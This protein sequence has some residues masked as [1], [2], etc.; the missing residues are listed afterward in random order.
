M[1]KIKIAINGANGRMGKAISSLVTPSTQQISTRTSNGN[2]GDKVTIS[3][4]IVRDTSDEQLEHIC[5]NCDVIVDFS[6]P[7]GL[8]RLLPYIAKAENTKL[9]VGTTG[10]SKEHFDALDDIS[11]EASVIYAP[12]TSLGANLLEYLSVKASNL[13]KTYDVEI[14]EAHHRNKKDSPSGTAISL[15][16]AIAEAKDWEFAN[17]AI[18]DRHQ[19]GL[20]E[21]KDIS[22]ASIRGGGIFG[23]HDVIFANDHE[24]FSLRHRALS[25]ATFAE[26]AILAAIWLARQK[27]AGLYS[28]QDV[29]IG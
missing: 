22:F 8:L 17:S 14:L 2:V 19:R 10:L 11:R 25:R 18:F 3:G 6:T 27:I 15:G 4:E 9:L 5:N 21:E 24:I 12:N 7:D 26:G 13:L 16:R 1:N 20:R 23:E 28:M 29:L